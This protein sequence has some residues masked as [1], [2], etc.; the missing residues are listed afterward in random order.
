MRYRILNDP[1]KDQQPPMAFMDDLLRPVHHETP[2]RWN[3]RAAEAGEL[4]LPAVRLNLSFPDPEG[5][6]ETAYADFRAFMTFSAIAESETGIP[7]SVV[8]EKTAC[9]EAYVIRVDEKGCVIAAADTE[10]VRRALIYLEDEMRRREGAF[11]PFGEIARRP[12]VRTRISRCFFSPPSHSPD[13]QVV[14]ELADEVDYYP[15]EYLN[16]LAHDGI[17]G[18]WLGAHVR[19]LIPSAI[20]PEY[21]ADGAR[22]VEKLNRVIEKCRR[23]GIGIYLFSVEPSSGYDNPAF[24]AHPELHG[25]K[26]WGN[27]HLLCPSTEEGAA[28]IRESIEGLFRAV[29]HLAGL[30]DITTGEACSA[31]GSVPRMDCPRCLEK[32]GSHAKTLAATERMIAETMKQ[33]APEAEFISWTYAQRTWNFDTVREAC[34]ERSADVIHMQNFEDFGRPVQLGKKRLALDYWLSYVGPGELMKESLTVNH[35]RGIRTY[36]KIQACSSHEISTVPYVPAPGIL[37]DKYKYMH[38]NGISGVLQCWYFGNYPCLMN[39]AASELAFEPFFPEKR[40][41]L[42]HLAASYWGRT[43]AATAVRAWEHFEAGYTNFPVSVSFEWYGPMQDS[44]VCPLRLKPV[45][46]PMSGT[47]HLS[48]MVGGDRLGEAL[49]NGHSYEEALEL[50]GRLT[51]EW[52]AGEALLSTLKGEGKTMREEQLSNAEALSLIFRSGYNILRF[53]T[54]RRLLGIGK[55]DS[56]AILDEMEAIAREEITISERLIPI[57]EADGRI[58]FH[59]EANGYKIFPK[60]LAWRIEEVKKCLA[61]EFP[62]VR[63]RLRQ[64]LAPL[65]FYLGEE[66]GA[67]TYHI[68]KGSIEDAIP[69]PFLKENG[70]ESTATTVSAASD[71]N[72]YTFRF[73]LQE[74]EGDS[75]H[76]FPEYRIFHPTA[77]F[78]LGVGGLHLTDDIHHS[79]YGENTVAE[80]ENYTCTVEQPGDGSVVYTLSFRRAPFG[81]E[82]G[83]PFR[84]RIFR[85]G[86]HGDVF[87]LPDRIFDRLIAGRFSPDAYGFF[88]PVK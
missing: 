37:Y 88:V 70:E 75:L 48:D 78:S 2:A 52:D 13:K 42:T 74:G 69:M 64:G 39:K 9:R 63:E 41:F 6:L 29:P 79:R 49:R 56:L 51:S 28:Y 76:I 80:R 22:R 20:V 35:R 19:D 59:S 72:G 83:E 77:S 61:E 54:L 66:E 85:Y 33:V 47:W 45:D 53:Y 3:Q 50:V 26:V 38:E 5:L 62:E 21:A 25:G 44:P 30:I 27:K 55:G 1:F 60:K 15:D 31:C 82:E 24:E 84:F 11:L 17:N 58:G 81:M 7:V 16:R 46:L 14:N 32:F 18:L 67:R 10:G 8:Y 73:C 87:A 65:A 34:E 68:Q 40:D 4:F 86:K 12:F 23:Y 71:E 36:A 57:C 43:D